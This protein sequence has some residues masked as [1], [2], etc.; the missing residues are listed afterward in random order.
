M[1]QIYF[2]YVVPVADVS[3]IPTFRMSSLCCLVY[4]RTVCKDLLTFT[5]MTFSRCKKL[6]P[7]VMVFMSVPAYKETTPCTRFLDI[8]ESIRLVV[9]PV[10]EGSEQQFGIRVII[11]HTW[12][13][14]GRGYPQCIQRFQHGCTFHRGA[15][16]TMQNKGHC[17]KPSLSEACTS[18]QYTGMINRFFFPDFPANNVSAEEGG[19]PCLP[20][21]WLRPR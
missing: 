8:F 17:C 16:V 7:T 20:G 18:N 10:L 5:C 6:Y 14:V 11:A 9:W 13:A 19:F 2:F 12:S 21:S 4:I 15:V 1:I 3:T